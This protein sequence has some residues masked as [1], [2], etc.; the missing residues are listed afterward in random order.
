M[1]DVVELQNVILEK[2]EGI[3]RIT[4]NRPDVMNAIDAKTIDRLSALI[5]QCQNDPGIR[6]VILTGAG[7]VFCSGIDLNYAQTLVKSPVDATTHLRK[8]ERLFTNLEEMDKPTI[9]AINGYALGEGCELTLV[10]DFRLASENARLGM[11]Y[12]QLGLVSTPGGICRLIQLVGLSKAKELALLGDMIEAEEALK[13][14]LVHKVVPA[15]DLEDNVF[16]LATRLANSAPL[17]I[18][19]AKKE[20]NASLK[21]E[22]RTAIDFDVRAQGICLRSEDAM[23]GIRAKLQKREPVFKGK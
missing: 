21:S 2:N 14:G 20:L 17:A 1:A 23:E 10:C 19:L 9:A 12:V 11:T 7:R 16:Q 5:E 18:T 3:A 15:Q 13:I 22:L 8:M 6:A 4:L